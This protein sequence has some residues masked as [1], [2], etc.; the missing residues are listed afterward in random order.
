MLVSSVDMMPGFKMFLCVVSFVPEGKKKKKAG[1]I[2]CGERDK[3]YSISTIYVFKLLF[4]PGGK[5]LSL[6]HQSV[7]FSL[8]LHY[9]DL[10]CCWFTLHNSFLSNLAINPLEGDIRLG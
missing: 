2:F 6:V 5:P 10:L 8:S 1:T 9:P 7:F 3:M 4:P